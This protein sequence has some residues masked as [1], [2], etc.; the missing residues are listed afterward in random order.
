[1]RQLR[2]VGPGDDCTLILES[3][4]GEEQFT[5][6]VDDA[7]RAA[8]RSS[9]PT[10]AKTEKDSVIDL[11]PRDIQMRV[12]SGEDPQAIA[13]EAGSSLE[14]VMRFAYPV[15]Q[16]RVRITD[17]ARRAR[18]RRGTDGQL[19]PFG[20]FS[21]A[22][23][24]AHGVDPAD[25]VWDA[26]RRDDGGWTVTAAFSAE[27]RGALA[28]FSFA[29]MNRTVSALD[30]VAADLLSERPIKALAKPPPVVPPNN[31]Q[32]GSGSIRLTAVPDDDGEIDEAASAVAALD[33]A[34]PRR[35]AAPGRS[36]PRRQ[37]ARTRP[38]P[39]GVE[40]ELFDQEA[41]D[42]HASGASQDSSVPGEP[43]ENRPRRADFAVTNEQGRPGSG[44]PP[45]D[46]PGPPQHKRSGRSGEKPRMPS[47]DDIL[48]GVR[49]KPD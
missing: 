27:G 11:R 45:P 10:A 23:L 13:D 3:A 24:I 8:S 21:A 31:D 15:L 25:V 5:V 29:L 32:D 6:T 26:F 2:L 28:K 12:R 48:L 37:R 7:L 30:D 40:D 43:A 47:W 41:L 16:E 44:S 39:I 42:P 9:R 49:R 18:A 20:E 34:G 36:T 17:E 35:G 1:M 22:R 4:D 19:V 14:K 38:V 33:D 46:E